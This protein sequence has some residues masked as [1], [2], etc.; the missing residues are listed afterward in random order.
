M[1]KKHKLALLLFKHGDTYMN[2]PGCELCDGIKKVAQEEEYP[3][4]V[5]VEKI[6]KGADMTLKEVKFLLE[7]GVGREFLKEKLECDHE[8]F[9]D[10]LKA[11]GMYKPLKKSEFT[12]EQIISYREEGLT[13]KAVAAKCNMS[14]EHLMTL[15]KGWGLV[16]TQEKYNIKDK[17]IEDRNNGMSWDSIARKY[18]ISDGKLRNLKKEW[19][20]TDNGKKVGIKDDVIKARESGMSWVA[21]AEKFEISKQHLLTLR[22]KWGIFE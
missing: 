14:Q 10:I 5:Y 18:G 20:I 2:C 13:W 1:R 4:I 12:K 16:E 15:R 7:K 6:N 3:E 21:I 8:E 11:I 9:R 22:K 19:G 17:V